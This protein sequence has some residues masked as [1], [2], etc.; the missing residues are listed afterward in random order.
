MAAAP[1]RNDGATIVCPR[2]E[3]AFQPVGRQR[4]CSPACRQALW[5]RQHATA[6][7]AIP[8]RSP[9]TTTVYCC[10]ECQ[11]RYLGQQ[12]CEDCGVFCR[13]LGPGGLCPHCDE[14]VTLQ[15]LL[16]GL[17]GGEAPRH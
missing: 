2:C 8:S 13:R 4:V 6:R 14:P 3:R 1:S 12:R 15:D 5:R 9:R 10:P 17:E 11:A 7:P 16:P